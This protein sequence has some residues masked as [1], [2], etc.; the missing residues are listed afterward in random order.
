MKHFEHIRTE[1]VMKKAAQYLNLDKD[2]MF[3][4][5]GIGPADVL[6][7]VAGKVKE[8]HAIDPNK[9]IARAVLSRYGRFSNILVQQASM[10]SLPYPNGYFTRIVLPNLSASVSDELEVRR[11][12]NELSRVASNNATIFVGGLSV[13][14]DPRRGL[15]PALRKIVGA[16]IRKRGQPRLGGWLSTSMVAVL[17]TWSEAPDGLLM[18]EEEFLGICRQYRLV[19]SPVRIELTHALSLSRTDFLLTIGRSREERQ[20]Q[21]EVPEPELLKNMER[22]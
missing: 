11:V 5:M 3:L 9:K 4:Q 1:F 10:T 6:D 17:K 18:S 2:D 12:V 13:R 22:K 19:G 14:K 8:C 7:F 21:P 16:W 15:V 20:R